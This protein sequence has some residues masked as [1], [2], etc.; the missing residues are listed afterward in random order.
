MER[1]EAT[2]PP[3]Y[4]RNARAA[5]LVYSIDNRESIDNIT[6]WAESMSVQR[7]GN[8]VMIRA[9]VGNKVDLTDSRD[10]KTK[11][12]TDTADACDI[13][14]DLVFEVSAKSGEGVQAMF[15][16]IARK[17]NKLERNRSRSTMPQKEDSK[18]SC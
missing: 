18:C 7:L 17:M 4:F 8:A 12:G 1:F 15:D 11:R 14:K 9:L 6:H 16:T 3:T 2:V 10:V 13:D 5:I